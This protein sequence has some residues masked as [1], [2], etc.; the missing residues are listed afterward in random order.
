MTGHVVKT[1]IGLACLAFI[2]VGSIWLTECYQSEKSCAVN[3]EG[4]TVVGSIVS[5]ILEKVQ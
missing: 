4:K 5:S 3:E 1:L 2:G